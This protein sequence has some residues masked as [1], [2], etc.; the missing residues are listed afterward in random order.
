MS[1]FIATLGAQLNVVEQLSG[2]SERCGG[3]D[4]AVV[5]LPCCISIEMSTSLG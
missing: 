1:L 2:I 4:C 3:I 5:A